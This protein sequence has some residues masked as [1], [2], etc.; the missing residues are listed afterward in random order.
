MKKGTK[1]PVVG[2]KGFYRKELYLEGESQHLQRGLADK[3]KQKITFESLLS[4]TT[5]L[6]KGPSPVCQDAPT[7][8]LVCINHGALHSHSFQYTDIL[9]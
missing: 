5:K 9:P 4:L 1:G 3:G 6:S 8:R 7:S 2:T